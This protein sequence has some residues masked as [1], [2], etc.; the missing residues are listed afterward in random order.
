MGY[1]FEG[2][3]TLYD[4]RETLTGAN[5]DRGLSTPERPLSK[6]DTPVFTG[7]GGTSPNRRHPIK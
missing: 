5:S 7:A 4:F 1:I 6:T 3:M 2:S